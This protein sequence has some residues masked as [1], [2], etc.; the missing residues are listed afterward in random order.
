MI[1]GELITLNNSDSFS[2]LEWKF[3]HHDDSVIG[4]TMTLASKGDHADIAFDDQGRCI[5]G[6]TKK[7]YIS[8]GRVVDPFKA[9][10]VVLVQPENPSEPIYR[11]EIEVEHIMGKHILISVENDGIRYE[12]NPIEAIE[13]IGSGLVRGVNITDIVGR[14]NLDFS[15]ALSLMK[16]YDKRMGRKAWT[17]NEM[18]VHQKAYPLGIKSN[19]QTALAWGMNE[20]DLFKCE[21]YLQKQTKEGSHEMYTPSMSDIFANDWYVIE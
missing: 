7:Q 19:K 5:S 16:Y 4:T 15:T 9:L 14:D 2:S 17:A 3:I 20:G 6:L 10:G 13:M 11:N 21:P 12:E 18:V 8:Q 1:C